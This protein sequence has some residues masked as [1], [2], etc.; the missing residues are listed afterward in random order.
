MSRITI[1]LPEKVHNRAQARAQNEPI[2]SVVSNDLAHYYA[3]VDAAAIEIRGYFEDSEVRFLSEALA[4]T[5][6]DS[7][8]MRMWP[9]MIAGIVEDRWLLDGLHRKHGIDA[10]KL[11]KKVK[12]MSVHQAVFLVDNISRQVQAA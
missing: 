10:K 8:T 5:H 6:L 4:G 11:V 2:A 12:G 3:L 7:S 9:S 1:S